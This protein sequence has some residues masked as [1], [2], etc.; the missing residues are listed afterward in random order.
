MRTTGTPYRTN[1]ELPPPI[2]NHLPPH[3]QDIYREAFNHSFATHGG[4]ARQEEIAH[5]RH[6]PPSNEPTKRSATNGCC[7]QDAEALPSWSIRHRALICLHRDRARA[8]EL[9]KAKGH[10]VPQDFILAYKWLNLAAARAPK[11]ERGYFIRLRDA[12]AS[13]L[14]P[15]QIAEGQRLAMLWSAGLP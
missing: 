7:F 9:C 6:G 11:R 15:A 1:A 13:K 14:S 8:I 10:G 2:R 5:A 3:A 12:V 4:D